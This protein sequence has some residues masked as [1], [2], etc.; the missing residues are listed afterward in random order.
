MPYRHHEWFSECFQVLEGREKEDGVKDVVITIT[1]GMSEDPDATK[2]ETTLLREQ[3]VQLVWLYVYKVA[4]P[5]VDEKNFM[6]SQG[7]TVTWI[8]SFRDLSDDVVWQVL[9][10]VGAGKKATIIK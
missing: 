7:D 6:D 9:E 10:A 5:I 8:E 2:E 3:G 1:D 4:G